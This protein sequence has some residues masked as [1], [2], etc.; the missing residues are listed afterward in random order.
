MLAIVLGP[1]AENSFRQSML[2]SQ[3]DPAVFFER[4]ISLIC[5][6]IAVALF[7]YPIASRMIRRRRA[8]A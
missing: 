6:L 8:A 5:I 4:P 7:V 3:G 2:A 1:L